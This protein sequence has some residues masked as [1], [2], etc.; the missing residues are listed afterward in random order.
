M[1]VVQA[2]AARRAYRALKT[3]PLPDGALERIIQA[4]TLAPSCYNNQ[5]WRIVAAQGESLVALQASLSEGNAWARR[6]PVI[7]ALAMRASD[8]CRLEDGREYAYFDSGLCAMNMMIQATHEGLVAHPI[9]GYNPKKAKAALGIP[10]DHVLI[11]LLVVAQHGDPAGE[12]G[13]ALASWQKTAETA[14]RNRKPQ[15]DL[16][17]TDHWPD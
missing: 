12:D 14:A 9:A 8:D 11:V 10:A 15:T 3:S 7:I 16:A 2:I 1:E 17:W 6:A 4:G 5:P 13:E